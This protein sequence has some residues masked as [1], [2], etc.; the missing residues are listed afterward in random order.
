[1]YISLELDQVVWHILVLIIKHLIYNVIIGIDALNLMR[2]TIDVGQKMLTTSTMVRV[3]SRGSVKRS[4]NLKCL[5][6]P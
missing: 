2:A 1:M 4:K 5:G 3:M 6:N